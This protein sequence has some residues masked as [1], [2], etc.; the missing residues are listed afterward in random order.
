M[1]VHVHNLYDTENSNL[2]YKI[3]F[4]KL[5]LRL[6]SS[7]LLSLRLLLSKILLSLTVVWGSIFE[8]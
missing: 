6:C 4:S 7:A 3:S 5:N 8:F 2:Q 1:K